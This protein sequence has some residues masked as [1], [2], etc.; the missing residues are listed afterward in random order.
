MTPWFKLPHKV[1][2]FD[3]NDNHN[4]PATVKMLVAKLALYVCIDIHTIAGHDGFAFSI[5]LYICIHR[6]TRY[7]PRRFYHVSN[8]TQANACR[9]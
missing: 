2:K 5:V 4:I 9:I 6:L 7:I 8:V 3:T 1:A